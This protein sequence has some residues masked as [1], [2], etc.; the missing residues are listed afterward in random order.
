MYAPE[1]AAVATP[2]GLVLIE[3]D[4]ATIARIRFAPG[5]EPRTAQTAVLRTAAEQLSAWFDGRLRTFDLPLA[6]AATPRGAVLRQ[7]IVAIGYGDT[8]GYGELAQAIGSSARAVG[9]ACAR[10]PFPLVVPCHRVLQAGGVLGPYSAGEGPTTKRWLLAF[11]Q[12]NR[13]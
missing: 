12:A 2:I 11:E 7:A 1:T 8:A 4:D 13:S 9:Q 10:N 3:G 6:A 5:G